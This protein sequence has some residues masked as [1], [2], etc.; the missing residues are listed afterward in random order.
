MPKKEIPTEAIVDLRRRLEQLPP[1]SKERRVLVQEVAQLYGI[2]ED[3]VYRTLRENIQVRTPSEFTSKVLQLLSSRRGQILG[4]EA[5]ANWQSWDNVT[6]YL[7]QS[8]MQSFIIELRSQTLGV[9]SFDW[10][11]DH[12]QEVPDKLADRILAAYKDD[13]NNR[14]GK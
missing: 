13:N 3:T 7:P 6:G 12:L 10:K 1:R 4:Y 9:G 11:Y 2:S 5:I 14:N 8:E